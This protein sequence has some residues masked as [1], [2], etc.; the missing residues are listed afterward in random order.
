MFDMSLCFSIDRSLDGIKATLTTVITQTYMFNM[1]LQP[2][3][4]HSQRKCS[5]VDGV[6]DSSVFGLI[7]CFLPVRLSLGFVFAHISVFVLL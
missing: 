3:Q 2:T 5:S 6:L 7:G 4:Q 1:H